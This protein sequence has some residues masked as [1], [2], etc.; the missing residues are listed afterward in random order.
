MLITESRAGYSW[1]D[2]SHT[3]IPFTENPGFEPLAPS[4]ADGVPFL[5]E[6]VVGQRNEE[7]L[8]TLSAPKG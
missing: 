3:C 2:K 7:L 6:F 1:E 4:M 5:Y 8:S